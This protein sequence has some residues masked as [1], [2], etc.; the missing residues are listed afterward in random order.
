MSTSG[1]RKGKEMKATGERFI[2]DDAWGYRSEIEHRHRYNLLGEVVKGKKVLDAACGSGYGTYI[3]AQNAQSATGIDISEEAVEFCKENY[4]RENLCYKRMSAAD[5]QFADNEFDVVISFETIEHLPFELQKAFLKE[6]TRVLKEDG[7]LIMSS[8]DRDMRRMIY[9]G[10]DNP[11]HIHEFVHEEFREFLSGYFEHIKFE[12][13]NIVEVSWISPEEGDAGKADVL[14]SSH[15]EKMLPSKY[16]LAI[17]AKKAELI[18]NIEFRSV[19]VP[20]IMQYFHETYDLFGKAYLYRDL[21]KG[22]VEE[23]KIASELVVD[24]DKFKVAYEF[25]ADKVR[26][27]RFDPCERCC[28]ISD[29]HIEANCDV[30]ISEINGEIEA[31]EYVFLNPDPNIMLTFLRCDSKTVKLELTGRMRALSE[32]E[33]FYRRSN[34]GGQAR[35]RRAA[36]LLLRHGS[37]F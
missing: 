27:L 2:T 34:V 3:I 36:C 30:E 10:I 5:M 15:F 16:V 22:F 37:R 26:G 29:L 18:E 35:F 8:P 28:A 17:C 23:D 25:D 9:H 21:G 32:M 4:K 12:A 19:F 24:G 13:Q 1:V 20:N 31:E 7:I 6:I 14:L 11:Y 33:V